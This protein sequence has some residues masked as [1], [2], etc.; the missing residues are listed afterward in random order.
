M[1]VT[2]EQTVQSP[3]TPSTSQLPLDMSVR[4]NVSVARHDDSCIQASIVANINDN[5][6]DSSLQQTTSP[7]VNPKTTDS[8]E[9][10]EVDNSEV[11]QTEIGIVSTGDIP[12]SNLQNIQDGQEGVNMSV[13][14]NNS[15]VSDVAP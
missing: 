5:V 8:H 2:Q 6:I 13:D 4:N 15:T 9:S 3:H 12:S 7:D 11:Q 14:N 10:T 1:E